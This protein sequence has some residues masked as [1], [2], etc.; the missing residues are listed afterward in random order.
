MQSVK[1]NLLAAFRYLL[2]PLVRLAVKNSVTYPDFSEALKKAYVD[3]ATR[4]MVASKMDATEEGI[5]LIAN[6]QIS[7]V[8]E[9]LQ[10]GNDAKYGKAVQEFSPLPTILAA[11]HTDQRYTGP[12][13]VLL[14]L[15]FSRTPAA[16][17]R[18]TATFTDLAQ[19]YCPGFTPRVLMDELIRIGAVQDVGNGFYRAIRRSYIPEP[20]SA[21]SIFYMARVVHNLCE[22]LEGNLRSASSGSKGLI[23]RSIFTVHGIPKQDHPA[24]HKFIHARGQVFAD[25]IDNW[26]SV[27]DVE[28]IQDPMQVGV[29]FYHYIVNEEDE[30]ALSKDLPNG[31][32]EE[33]DH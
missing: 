7:E 26:L 8:R 18:A 16:A 19:T 14:D 4:Q 24:F 2:K 5:S 13:G 1:E 21:P 12:Y 30:G 33:N 22:T 32:D 15:E 31:R 28:G 10:A 25:D 27:R 29:G 3:V 9:I 11:W 17:E 6:I 20:L 23:E